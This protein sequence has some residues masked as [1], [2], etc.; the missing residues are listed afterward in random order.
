MSEQP[1]ALR[2]ADEFRRLIVAFGMTER[3][4][5]A[6]AERELRRLHALCEEMGEALKIG[7]ITTPDFLDWVADRFIHVYGET[8]NM[9]FIH[10]LR[11]RS[12]AGRS[13]LAK[14]KESK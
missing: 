10:C 14:W 9:D 8:P 6:A 2:L 12:A 7:E 5:V 4:N 11:S 1:E 3:G 13:A